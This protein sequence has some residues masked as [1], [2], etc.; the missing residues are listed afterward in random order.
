MSYSSR[1]LLSIVCFGYDEIRPTP[2]SPLSEFA[3]LLAVEEQA[4]VTYLQAG[5]L[6]PFGRVRNA[7]S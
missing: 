6:F 1:L 5:G 2:N 3:L 7:Y 4:T